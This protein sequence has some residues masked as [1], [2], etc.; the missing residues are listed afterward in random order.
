MFLTTDDRL[1]RKAKQFPNIF[2]IEI[3]NPTIWLMN[4][5][6]TEEKNDET[7]GN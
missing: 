1:Q 7:D 4:I 5:W 6:Q 2:Q 3:E